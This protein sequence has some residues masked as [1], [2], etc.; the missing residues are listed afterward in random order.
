MPP[1]WRFREFQG[2]LGRTG[3][4]YMRF[5]YSASLARDSSM[6]EINKLSVGQALDKLRGTDSPSSQMNRLDG[7]I[8][9]LNE[10]IQRMR[11]T[12]RR[13]ERDQRAAVTACDTRATNARRGTWLV[14]MGIAGGIF[15][16]I[17]ILAWMWARS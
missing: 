1:F 2:L 13:V 4:G 16:V 12:R 15:V 11:A 10:E 14:V 7:K 17:L 3:P 8:D 6:A 9:A 5:P